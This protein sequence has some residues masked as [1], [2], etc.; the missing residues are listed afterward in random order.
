MK[1]GSFLPQ[2]GIPLGA[3][4]PNTTSVETRKK[5]AQDSRRGEENPV[6]SEE[7]STRWGKA[8]LKAMKR[9]PKSSVSRAAL[10]RQAK[11]TAQA[12]A[13]GAS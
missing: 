11:S 5:A 2:G 10:S 7:G 9:E 3:P 12:R 6:T 4:N 8:R 13:D 1:N